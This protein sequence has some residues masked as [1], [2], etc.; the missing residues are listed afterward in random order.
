MVKSHTLYFE[1]LNWASSFL[2]EHQKEPYIAEYMLLERNS[3][4][5]TDLVR[6][7]RQPMPE[8]ESDQL[9]ADLALVIEGLPPQYIIGSCEFY[10]QRFNV[11]E[12]TLI[13]RPETEE[14]V[15]LCLKENQLKP[16]LKVIDV[17]TGTGAIAL[18]LK[19]MAPDWQVTAV[20]ISDEAL[21]VAKE[22]GARLQQEVC[23]LKSDLLA[24]VMDEQF[25]LI[26]SNPPYI[27]YD[28]WQ[29][30]DI[31]V[32]THEPKLALFAENNGLA[33]Y[34]RLAEEAKHVIKSTGKIYLEIGY[35]Q[36]DAVQRIFKQRFPTKTV[37]IHQDLNGHDRMIEVCG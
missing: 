35:R 24:E 30:M 29:E 22:N 1:V 34:E 17:G 6:H 9:K 12:D 23:F 36:G 18:S 10:G 32:R 28:E 8:G 15:E 27:G 37:I 4:S 11:T 25:D 33:L 5:K 20:D 26:I 14:L 7:Y 31:S 21:A 13:P 16:A 2:E 19:K 3:W